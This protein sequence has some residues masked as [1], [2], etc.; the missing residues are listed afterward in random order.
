MFENV[1]THLVDKLLST[2]YSNNRRTV[3]CVSWN[4][5]QSHIISVFPHK[6]CSIKHKVWLHIRDPEDVLMTFNQSV[7]IIHCYSLQGSTN[8]CIFC[9]A[10]TVK[11]QIDNLW[12]P[13]KRCC[14]KHLSITCLQTESLFIYLWTKLNV[15]HYICYSDDFRFSVPWWRR[16]ESLISCR[17][18][19]CDFFNIL[20]IL[21]LSTFT[22]SNYFDKWKVEIVQMLRHTV[23]NTIT[24]VTMKEC[25]FSVCK[26]LLGFMKSASNL[27]YH[28]Y[29]RKMSISFLWRCRIFTS[30][31]I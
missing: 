18:F 25:R 5:C 10:Q 4:V 21:S 6:Y 9:S 20:M 7:L 29:Y 14:V 13:V 28:H 31:R 2:M 19:S 3:N 27:I 17:V 8:T 16:R 11:K 22:C 15:R 1:C 24:A 23:W 26:V 30:L 12:I